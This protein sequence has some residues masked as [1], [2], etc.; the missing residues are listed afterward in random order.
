[1]MQ[2][3]LFK[4]VAVYYKQEECKPREKNVIKE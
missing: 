2:I 1:M 3:V 4:K